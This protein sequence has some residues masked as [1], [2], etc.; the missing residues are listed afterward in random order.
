VHPGYSRPPVQR[1]FF[2][3]IYGPSPLSIYTNVLLPPEQFVYRHHS[4]S[5]IRYF[6][7]PRKLLKMRSFV[8]L[9]FFSAI[10][11]FVAAKHQF[12]AYQRIAHDIFGVEKRQTVT[13][14]GFGDTCADVCGPGYIS[15][16]T[17]DRCYDPSAGQVC[18]S[19]SSMYSFQAEESH[20]S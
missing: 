4:L 18:C 7:P 11:G 9:A 2:L 5:I 15:C 1:H 8:S 3:C 19:D 17:P 14:V 13:C 20:G 12:E 16:V 6:L 10:T